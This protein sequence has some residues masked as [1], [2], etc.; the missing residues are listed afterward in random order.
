M[1]GAGCKPVGAVHGAAWFM[2][3]IAAVLVWIPLILGLANAATALS[4][5]WTGSLSGQVLSILF[6]TIVMACCDAGRRAGKRYS[7]LMSVD[8]RR[9]VRDCAGN[10]SSVTV[11]VVSIVFGAIALNSYGTIDGT[12]GLPFHW[13]IFCLECP[14][15]IPILLYFVPSA[16]GSLVLAW[17]GSRYSLASARLSGEGRLGW[18]PCFFGVLVGALLLVSAYCSWRMSEYAGNCTVTWFNNRHSMPE[19]CQST[20]W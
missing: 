17:F 9:L 5:G 16:C 4:D 20:W 11:V 7:W 3:V 13:L 1:S 15:V 10:V 18:E 12:S 2:R 8:D 14:W 6:C 19:F